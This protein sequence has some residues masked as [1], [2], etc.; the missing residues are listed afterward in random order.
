MTG[1]DLLRSRIVQT[2]GASAIALAS[3]VIVWFEGYEPTPYRDPVGILTVCY[4]HTT[5]VVPGRTYTKEECEQILREDM[6]LAFAAVDRHV[7][8]TLPTLTHAALASFVFNVGEEKF[9]T[10]TLLRKLNNGEEWSACDE[11]K[12]WVY[13]K[14]KKLPG[15]VKRRDFEHEMCVKGFNGET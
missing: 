8:V 11:L 1:L 13:A 5:R 9:R 12:R 7:I 10:S 2:A 15:L 3:I 14:G 4:G 6:A